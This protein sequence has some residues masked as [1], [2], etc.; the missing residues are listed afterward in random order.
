MAS[1]EHSDQ[2]LAHNMTNAHKLACM[3]TIVLCA[4]AHILAILS[5]IS[6]IKVC[7]ESGVHAGH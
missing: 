4:L 3:N 2:V 7:M 1:G 5:W 6:E